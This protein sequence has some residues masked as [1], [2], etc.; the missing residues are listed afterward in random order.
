MLPNSVRIAPESP[1]RLKRNRRSLS[2]G[3]GVRIETESVFRMDRIFHLRIPL[4]ARLD[5]EGKRGW[6][7]IEKA[8]P[9][10]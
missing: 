7:P 8:G 10:R 5:S 9:F 1:F 4:K 2:I 6:I 3:I